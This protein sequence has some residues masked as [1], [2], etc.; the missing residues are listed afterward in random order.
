MQSE[1]RFQ[2]VRS[3]HFE[4]ERKVSA[5]GNRTA[6]Y[7]VTYE[8]ALLLFDGSEGAAEVLH[9][10]GEIARRADATIPE[11]YVADTTCDGVTVV[12]GPR[13]ESFA[14]R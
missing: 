5:S 12:D 9:H 4:S 13:R 7:R 14:T 1:G 6:A 11:L 2:A 3:H 8:N 10:P